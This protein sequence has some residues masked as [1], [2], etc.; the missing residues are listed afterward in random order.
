MASG[1]SQRFSAAV[2]LS[3]SIYAL[4]SFWG[5]N[6]YQVKPSVTS[7]SNKK[8]EDTVPQSWMMVCFCNWKLLSYT[9]VLK[10]NFC[11]C[12]C[13]GQ[14]N[15][16]PGLC[17][18]PRAQASCGQGEG[19]HAACADLWGCQWSSRGT[20]YL[21]QGLEPEVVACG[22][23]ANEAE[24]IWGSSIPAGWVPAPPCR[25]IPQ[26]DVHETRWWIISTEHWSMSFI[27]KRHL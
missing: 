24:L 20:S 13:M 7:S 21:R 19:V 27:L 12:V 15:S 23:L 16:T 11:S 4:S 6:A 3:L 17:T 14:Q 18:S 25:L 5:F 8:H 9:T 10:T 2:L 1:T 26:G 22:W